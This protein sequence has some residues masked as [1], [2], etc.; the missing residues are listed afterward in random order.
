MYE[1]RNCEDTVPNID[2]SIKQ[3]LTSDYHPAHWFDYFMP[4][5]KKRQDLPQVVSVA[6]LT[7]WKNTKAVLYNE[8]DGGVQY[9]SFEAFWVEDIIKHIRVYMHNGIYTSPQVIYNLDYPDK[10]QI[11]GYAIVNRAIVKNAHQRQR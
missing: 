5:E 2:F 4:I 3:N 11:N 9:P 1:I 7:T 10:N 8:G 6:Q